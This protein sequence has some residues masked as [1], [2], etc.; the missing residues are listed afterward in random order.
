M[1]SVAAHG[2]ECRS[3]LA[4]AEKRMTSVRTTIE[5]IGRHDRRGAR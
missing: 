2:L 4:I 5:E 1:T 3:M